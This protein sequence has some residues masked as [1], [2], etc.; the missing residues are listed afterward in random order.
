MTDSRSV[1]RRI[2]ADVWSS[3]NVGAMR[4]LFS[5]DLAFMDREDSSLSG[6]A[7]LEELTRRWHTGFPDMQE[8]VL[9]LVVDG[10]KAICRF[11]LTG[12]HLGPFLGIQPTGRRIAIEGVDIYALRDGKIVSLEYVQD[13][14]GLLRQLGQLPA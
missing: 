14:L 12:T 7:G 10:D 3:G 9:D 2:Y 6:I 13:T 8:E 4:E 11:R 5:P 1:V